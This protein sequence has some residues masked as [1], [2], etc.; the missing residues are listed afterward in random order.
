MIIKCRLLLDDRVY[1]GNGDQNLCSP[2]RHGLSDG[3]LVQITRIIVVEG[4]PGK[5][6][7]I[8]RRL[9][10]SPRW[11]VDFVELG[12]RLERKIRNK[13]SFKH[14]PMGDSFQDRAVLSI[15]RMGHGFASRAVCV[16]LFEGLIVP[17][18]S[19]RLEPVLNRVAFAA[20]LPL[21]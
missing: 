1:I 11:P 9:L 18:L 20:A 10:S 8:T 16:G 12:E 4:E 5:V 6:P 7:E 19:L 3:K 15:V 2:V 13:S 21:I 14:H 17:D